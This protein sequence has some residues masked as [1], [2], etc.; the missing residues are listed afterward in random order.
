VCTLKCHHHSL[1][2][3]H[4]HLSPPP[5]WAGGKT[6]SFPL[7][8]GRLGWW[9]YAAIFICLLS[10]SQAAF[11]LTGITITADTITHEDATLHQANIALDLT[12]SD[13]A[14]VQAETLEYGKARLDKAHITVDLKANTTM[15]VKAKHILMDKVEAQNST[16]YL[17]YAKKTVQPTVTFYSDIK[18]TVDKA[19]SSLQINCFIPK[20]ATVEVWECPGGLFT[21]ERTRV[22]FNII[23]TPQ[24]HGVD[25][26]INFTDAN[27]SDE[28]GLHAGDKLTGKVK[29]SAELQKDAAKKDVWL[30]KGLFNWGEGELFWQPFYFGKAGNEF[31]VSGT[32][33]APMLNIEQANLKINEVGNMSASAEIN[34]K[35][36]EV[37]AAKVSAK[38]VDFAGLYALA[39]KPMVEKSAFGNLKVSGRADWKIDVKDLQ[40]MSFEL[41]LKDA[42]I[43]DLNGKFSLSDIN[44]HI[45]WDYEVPQTV[46]LAYSKGHVLKIPLG[47]INLKAELNRY[48]LTAPS[49]V[50]PVLDG[51]LKIED[52]SAAYLS[53]QWFWHLK[54]QLNPI[55]MNEFSKTL[56][57]P[58]MKGKID[59][60]VPLITYANKQLVMDG[61]M[62]FNMFNG[63]V[64]MEGLRIQDPLGRV[65]R[66]YANLQMRDIDLGDLTRTFNFGAIEGKLEGDVKDLQLENWKPVRMDAIIQTA[67]GKHLKKV[68][69][70]AVENIT[71]LGGE[72]TAAALQRTFLR[73]FKE[74]NY[75]KIGLSCQ[76]R[77]DICKMGGVESTPT[78]YIIVKGKGAPTVNVNGYT[79]YVSLSDLIARMKRITDSNSKMI[80]K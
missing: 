20:K 21:A 44:A 47:A 59:G 76:L 36:Q 42:N 30:W 80:V 25:A 51:A 41:N 7:A 38:D 23:I 53:Q 12:G 69:Q 73:F 1:L 64:S 10:L 2:R 17:D 79:E 15:L 18:Q 40:P 13:I 61:K 67:D 52:V 56:G 60:Q 65:P 33:S 26:E 6:S 34:V 29:M 77:Q 39:L 66:L 3:F 37:K 63:N 14:I 74:F 49:L 8:G 5:S 46:T 75:E 72:G 27:F 24:A 9:C 71:A 70:R 28:S 58:E 22:P 54:M 31:N 4:P 45:P 50:I 35:T 43:E 32:Y 48:S 68:S 62:Q 78:G 55:S 57:W 16:I 11:A 19:W